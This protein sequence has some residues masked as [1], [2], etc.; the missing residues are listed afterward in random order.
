MLKKNLLI[1]QLNF[2]SQISLQF[3][4]LL[5]LLSPL[6]VIF[7][8][9]KSIRI[10][11]RILKKGGIVKGDVRFWIYG[12][13]S[14]PTNFVIMGDGIDNSSVSKIVVASKAN[15]EIGNNVGITQSCIHCYNKISI[16]DN[17]KIGA[18]CLI[19]D[20][21]FHSLDW[22]LRLNEKTDVSDVK[23]SPVVIDSNVFVGARSIITKGVV[24]GRNTIIA[25]GSV[26]ISDIPDNC[27]A[28]GNPCKVIRNITL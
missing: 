23:T 11:W 21:N 18:G 28:G 10:V 3:Q 19:M 12:M 6:K 1:M 5:F 8:K 4:S 9:C 2:L 25:A 24:I 27:I 22:N 7:Y 15:L 14:I 16:G 13:F 26:V 17:V 20:S